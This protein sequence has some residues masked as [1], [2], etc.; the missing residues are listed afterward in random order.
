[1]ASYEQALARVPDCAE[2][3]LARGLLLDGRGEPL[4]PFEK[5]KSAEGLAVLARDERL[6]VA[7]GRPA[8]RALERALTADPTPLEVVTDEDAADAIGA[9]LRG[10]SRRAATLH[11]HPDA[12]LLPA[13]RHE[14]R[15][16]LPDELARLELPAELLRELA[17]AAPRT[18]IVAA[19]DG[20]EPASFAYAA[21]ESESHWDV[22][23]DTLESHRRRGLATSAFCALAAAMLASGKQPVWGARDDNPASAELARSLGFH[24]HRRVVTFRAPLVD[25]AG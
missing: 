5:Q 20:G 23:V 15:A 11:V 2:R 7:V 10:W 1:M 14:A 19:L 8:P 12:G 9:H 25:A 18:R 13:P 21:A 3:C 17:L 16:L 4:E 22:S 24:P 6:L